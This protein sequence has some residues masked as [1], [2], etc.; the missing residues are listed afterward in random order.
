M[1]LI[2]SIDV[3]ETKYDQKSLTLILKNGDV[4]E[5]E[6]YGDCCSN[7]YLEDCDN[8][9]ALQDATLLGIEEVSGDEKWPDEYECHRWTF[10][11]FRTSKGMATFS[12][13]NESNGYYNGHLQPLFE[14][15]YEKYFR[16]D[17]FIT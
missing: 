14:D 4:I 7:S 11:K 8:I 17:W 9:E 12:L 6:A 5:F 13:R 10:Y 3:L 16:E 2:E 1:K 15:I